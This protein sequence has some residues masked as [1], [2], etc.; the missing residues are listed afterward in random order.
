MVDKTRRRKRLELKIEQTKTLRDQF[1][2]P[3]PMLEERLTALREKLAELE[4]K[5]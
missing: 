1:S 2:T 5:T 4:Q 3:K